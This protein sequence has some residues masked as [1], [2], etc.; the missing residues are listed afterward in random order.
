MRS[1]G[2]EERTVM[3]Y[4]RPFSTLFM[5]FIFA[6][7]GQFAMGLVEGESIVQKKENHTLVVQRASEGVW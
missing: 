6:V 1:K 4:S 2:P 5:N 3:E 7:G